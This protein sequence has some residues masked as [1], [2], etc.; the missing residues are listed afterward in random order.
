MK[1][2]IGERA[3]KRAHDIVKNSFADAESVLASTESGRFLQENTSTSTAIAADSAASARKAVYDAG[4]YVDDATIS[5][6]EDGTEGACDGLDLTD[7]SKPSLRCNICFAADTAQ[8]ELQDA[9]ALANQTVTAA[10]EVFKAAT[11]ASTARVEAASNLTASY[12]AAKAEFDATVAAEEAGMIACDSA[13]AAEAE[14]LFKKNET[15]SELNL[16]KGVVEDAAKAYAAAM[17]DDETAEDRI[18]AEDDALKALQY[19]EKTRD[20][21][22]AALDIASSEYSDALTTET[23]VCG[24]YDNLVVAR[25]DKEG[26]YNE[27]KSRVD[28][29]NLV[30]DIDMPYVDADGDLIPDRF[31]AC[32][33]VVGLRDYSP[34]EPGPT[35]FCPSGCPESGSA[36]SDEDGVPDCIDR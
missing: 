3:A 2:R 33:G 7:D 14:A 1:A 4:P 21:L 26:T 19:A 16:A 27:L 8:K 31:D 9:E 20:D 36:D 32:P 5:C 25:A 23:T 28:S 30:V 12:A 11:D 18:R 10:N 6:A 15:E 29:N 22:Q 13:K 24:D 35:N 17:A 34:V